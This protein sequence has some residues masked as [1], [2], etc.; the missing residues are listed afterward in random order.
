MNFFGLMRNFSIR[1]RMRGAIGM[2]LALFALVG[3]TAFFGGRQM[4]ELNE[5]LV[6]HAVNAVHAVGDVRKALGEVR[7][8]EKSMVI[9]Y[10]DGVAVLKHRE[11]WT[12]SIAQAKK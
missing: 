12:Q 10:E 9:D 11:A 5:A 1:L 4:T 3:A 7:Q 6:H 2:V 8:H